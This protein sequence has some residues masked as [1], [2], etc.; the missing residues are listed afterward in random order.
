MI[1][2]R[3]LLGFHLINNLC[4]QDNYNKGK[5]QVCIF[6]GKGNSKFLQKVIADKRI[7]KH[8]NVAQHEWSGL[9]NKFIQTKPIKI[10]IHH[11]DSF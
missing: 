4:I 8:R 6:N 1:D 11:T 9:V 10:V 2:I 3:P 7:L 5:H